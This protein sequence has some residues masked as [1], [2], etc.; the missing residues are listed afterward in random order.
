MN[1]HGIP[2]PN[3]DDLR[4]QLDQIDGDTWRVERTIKRTP[5]EET[6]LVYRKGSDAGPFIRKIISGDANQGQAYEALFQAQSQGARFLHVPMIYDCTQADDGIAV[7][8]E[9]IPGKTLGEYVRSVGA[10]ERAFRFAA[11]ALCDALIELHTLPRQPIIHRDIKPSNA[12]L[13]PTGITL[14]DLGIARSWHADAE[15]DTVHF[16]TP[17]YAP[18]EQFG[19]E[20]TGITG[21]IF[22]AG[23]TL[24]FCCTGEDPT[25]ALRDSGFD[26]PRIPAWVRPILVK[27]TRFDPAAR[28]Q[29]AREMR[30]AIELA[31]TGM[32]PETEPAAESQPHRQAPAMDRPETARPQQPAKSTAVQSAPNGRIGL[33]YI[34]N[35]LVICLGMYFLAIL[36]MSLGSAL[37]NPETGF[38]ALSQAHP[39]QA[40]I[41]V[42]EIVAVYLVFVVTIYLA[43]FKIHLRKHPPFDKFTWRQ[44]L[45]VGLGFIAIVVLA[46]ALVSSLPLP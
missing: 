3:L 31:M 36:T 27:A 24:A 20:Q 41:A 46:M 15:T 6:Q 32:P 33:K 8:M 30:T 43:S 37:S 2:Q 4:A 38:V 34:W 11:P 42:I 25:S 12:M 28:Y 39:V 9:Y 1:A 5:F 23:M 45:P 18:P 19:F 13:S 10:G 40:I 35:A 21:D 7:V 29:S 22:A 16:G 26:D 14:I 44:E 17:G